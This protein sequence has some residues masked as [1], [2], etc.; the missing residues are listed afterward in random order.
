[1]DPKLSIGQA[2]SYGLDRITT[3]GGAILLVVYVLFQL[4]TQVS[5]QSLFSSLLAELL[6]GEE[7]TGMYPLA[8]DL[9]VAV[10][11]GLTA[12]LVL[13]G[14]VLGVVTIRALYS[15]INDVPTADHTRRLARTVGVLLVV[16]IVTFV[17]VL[18]GSIFFLVPGIF[19]GVSLIFAT[20]A[21]AI[22]DGGVVESLERS[23]ELTSGNRIELF[24]LGVIMGVVGGL[25]GFVFGIVGVFAPVVGDLATTIMSG[26][27]SLFGAAV[28]IGAYRQLAGEREPVSTSEW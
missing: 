13:V 9:P 10:S 7:T 18:I 6:S 14:S 19:L 27:L 3:R 2:L 20:V 24:V 23:W 15:D 22:E 26:I 11:G 28:L 17:A 25:I 16:S 5:V 21:V 12:L 1:M 8:V 4:V